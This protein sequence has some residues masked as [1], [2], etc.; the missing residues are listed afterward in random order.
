[1]KTI[2]SHHYPRHGNSSKKGGVSGSSSS[3][4]PSLIA[5]II[6]LILLY[7]FFIFVNHFN[8]RATSEDKV[9][10]SFVDE[11]KKLVASNIMN[12]SSVTDNPILKDGNLRSSISSGANALAASTVKVALVKQSQL[13]KSKGDLASSIA[14]S[15][16]AANNSSLKI[17]TVTY[18]S[19]GG[20]DDRFC[21]AIESSIRNGFDL[22]ILGWGTKWLGLSQKLQAAHSFARAL[23]KE[24][25][26]LFTGEPP[27]RA[28]SSSS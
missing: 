16:V 2:A 25:V 1:M 13:S 15:G 20:R 11:R 6:A 7:S 18:A 22:V 28:R 17:H 26:M 14:A 23:P 5:S 3:N 10:E 21:R 4:R 8:L 24:E 9:F 27:L 19:H 12:S